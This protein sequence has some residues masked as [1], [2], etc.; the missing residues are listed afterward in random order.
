MTSGLH[1]RLVEFGN[2]IDVFFEFVVGLNSSVRDIRLMHK[3]LRFK[4]LVVI[5]DKLLLLRREAQKFTLLLR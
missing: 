2:H 4:S 3:V 1:V 5:A